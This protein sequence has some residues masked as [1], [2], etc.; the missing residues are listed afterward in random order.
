MAAYFELLQ[1]GI[2]R[3]LQAGIQEAKLDAWYLFSECFHITRVEYFLKQK[4]RLT[5]KEKE[6]ERQWEEFLCR[7][8]K[9]E[10][11]QY[12]LGVQEFMGLPFF[13]SPDVL[14]PRQDTE[15]LVEKALSILK[16]EDHILD[17]CTG[18]GCILLSLMKLGKLSY[19]VGVDISKEALS[20]ARKNA[21]ALGLDAFFYQ[22]DLFHAIDKE[23]KFDIIVSNPPYITEKEMK[24]LMPEVA[25][26]EP[27]LALFGG[28]DGLDFYYKIAKL[29]K[30]FLTYH[31]SLMMEIGC[32]QALAV[33][34]ILQENGYEEIEIIQ[35]LAGLD[36]IVTGKYLSYKK[37]I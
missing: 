36:R 25:E 24:E 16:Q 17:M 31:G 35:D 1:K 12:I 14:I 34:K 28:R 23:E 15:I 6:A 19:G 10:P 5:E 4:E 20:I 18:S 27:K 33:K 3:L 26:Y 11:L 37:T 30:D 9:R 13:V 2:E 8:E 21:D 32:G 29:A 22:S 7:R